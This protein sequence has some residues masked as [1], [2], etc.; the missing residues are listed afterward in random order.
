MWPCY[1]K[2]ARALSELPQPAPQVLSQVG[3]Q[4]GAKTHRG[5]ARFLDLAGT[6]LNNGKA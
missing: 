6:R 3:H 2:G 4:Q 1:E 5:K